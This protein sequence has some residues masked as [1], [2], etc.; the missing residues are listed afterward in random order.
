MK[1]MRVILG[2]RIFDIP[3]AFIAVNRARYYANIDNPGL[4]ENTWNW[5]KTYEYEYGLVMNDPDVG[6]GWASGNMDWADVEDEAI[7]IQATPMEDPHKLW[8]NAQKTIV[9]K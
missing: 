4:K 1:Y 8:S 2:S 6:I 3:L 7:E 9:E 5:K